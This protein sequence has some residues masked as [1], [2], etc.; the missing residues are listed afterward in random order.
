MVNVITAGVDSFS[1][2]EVVK[3]VWGL[4]FKLLRS[5]YII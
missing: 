4:F 2:Q 3:N 1:L 5:I